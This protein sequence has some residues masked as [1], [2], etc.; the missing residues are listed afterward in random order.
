MLGKVKKG[1]KVRRTKGHSCTFIPN[2]PF[3]PGGPTV[4][5]PLPWTKAEDPD[6]P[7]G[8]G[9]P[10]SPGSPFGPSLLSPILPLRPMGPL[11]PGSPYKRLYKHG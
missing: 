3:S 4:K 7:G 6:G 8:P 1:Q 5:V 11:K 2:I 9:G 10:G